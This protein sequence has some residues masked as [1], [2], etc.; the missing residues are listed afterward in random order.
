MAF[1][2]VFEG[3][4][5]D[6]TGKEWYYEIVSLDSIG[7]TEKE[8]IVSAPGVSLTYE[9]DS[10]AYS[11]AM[12]GSSL[13]M[14]LILT[15]NQLTKLE[16]LIALD[17]GRAGILFYNKQ[18]GGYT[19]TDTVETVDLGLEWVGHLLIEST[20]I[21]IVNENH[22]V[23]LLFTCGLGSLKYFDWTGDSGAYT[24][25]ARLRDVL[26]RA[27]QKTPGYSLL[28]EKLDTI[29]YGP[30]LAQ[31]NFVFEAGLP[32]A[33]SGT[34][35]A[36][37]SNYE[38]GALYTNYVHS[39]TFLKPKDNTERH[40]N[41]FEA[42]EF[43]NCYDVV[44]DVCKTLG[45]CIAMTRGGWFVWNRSSLINFSDN[46]DTIGIH[47]HDLRWV[48]SSG[49]TANMAFN[50]TS[51]DSEYL[52]NTEFNDIFLSNSDT[53]YTLSGATE[54]RTLPISGALM[55]HED[56]ESDI[57]VAEGLARR[58][59]RGLDPT[60]GF[61]SHSL[62]N[63]NQLS[64]QLSANDQ[65]SY[66]SNRNYGYEYIFDFTLYDYE[67]QNVNPSL[68]NSL[69]TDNPTFRVGFPDRTNPNL[70]VEGG[71]D[72]MFSL[73]G[74][75]TLRK[76]YTQSTITYSNEPGNVY[77]LKARIQVQHTDGTI[78]RL[79]RLVVVDND[80]SNDI[81]WEGPS[82]FSLASGNHKL[83]TYGDL[84]W[85]ADDGVGYDDA[86]YEIM[87]PHGDNVDNDAGRENV[88]TQ[89]PGLHEGQNHYAGIHLD[90]D[91]TE[92]NPLQS[93]NSALEGAYRNLYFKEGINFQ[94]PGDDSDL[95]KQVILS[96]RFSC[97]DSEGNTVFESGTDDVTFDGT[98]PLTTS[99]HE[100]PE[101]LRLAQAQI[102]LGNGS[103]DM[104]LLT[105]ATGGSGF[106]TLNIGSSRIGSRNGLLNPQVTGHLTSHV[107]TGTQWDTNTGD[108]ALDGKG[109]VN[110]RW[111]PYKNGSTG[112]PGESAFP[113]LHNLLCHEYVKVYGA[114]RKSFAGAIV[115]R[116]EGESFLRPYQIFKTEYYDDTSSHQIMM[117][118]MAWSMMNGT[119]FEGISIDED[120]Y[121]EVVSVE[122][123]KPRGPGSGRTPDKPGLG[124]VPD[125]LTIGGLSDEIDGIGGDIVAIQGKTD[126]ITGDADG[127][128]GITFANGSTPIDADAVDD[129]TAGNKF[130]TSD[131]IA[132]LGHITV[133]SDVDLNNISGV[134]DDD[135]EKLSHISADTNGITGITVEEGD[136]II[137]TGAISGFDTAVSD[138]AD[139][140]ANSEK[141]SFSG[142]NITALS[143]VD[144]RLGASDAITI[145]QEDPD[146][147]EIPVY[148]SVPDYTGARKFTVQDLYTAL[149]T[150][151]IDT[152]VTDGQGTLPDFT[153]S[154]SNILGD[155]DNDGAVG[156]A[157]LLAF[158]ANFGENFTTATQEDYWQNTSW[159]YDRLNLIPPNP[160]AY[161]N[162]PD[163]NY[164]WRVL[165]FSNITKNQVIGSAGT[166]S[167]NILDNVETVEIV[168]TN[169]QMPM[170]LFPLKTFQIEPGLGTTG[171]V[172]V[173]ANVVPNLPGIKV[174]F[175]CEIKT[176][177]D[178]D[179][180][181]EMSGANGDTYMSI[182][183]P[184]TLENAGQQYNIPVTDIKGSMVWPIISNTDVV[185]IQ[186]RWFIRP[187][188]LRSN[189][190]TGEDPV[191]IDDAE[192]H[193]NFTYRLGK[194]RQT[195]IR[196]NV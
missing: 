87:I 135:A 29:G 101:R 142:A 40:R 56:A 122:E 161:T 174:H 92:E 188:V 193:S 164:N 138:N 41:L 7:N 157:D 143:V 154:T 180:P 150:S 116:E 128:S 37:E 64:W 187:Y 78:Y 131:D 132:K 72:F 113:S 107:Y 181:V 4:I 95:F 94:F 104:D 27:L 105:R 33:A 133:S 110:V 48:V 89:I 31:Y 169:D 171:S 73:R 44:E 45:A 46:P 108:D 82:S 60:P 160:F 152:I 50:L 151:L 58:R 9:S 146:L 21:D 88:L 184:V 114:Q 15:D 57:V 80:S 13:N 166:L 63:Q 1:S 153:G 100:L 162:T 172:G 117:T 163:G 170:S 136:T 47:T 179:D 192:Y 5:S 155:L 167:L 18:P 81:G 34:G 134:S 115:S 90:Y 147:L 26:Y 36:H 168:N 182:S 65:Y 10:L 23:D 183:F 28:L 55:T 106:E 98:Y 32:Q 17:E 66:G 75:L 158:L 30:V 123:T 91:D 68:R 120:R 52:G 38:Y 186:L 103:E 6:A 22:R 39:R 177:D 112:G 148:S 121:T 85:I 173:V 96:W 43:I 25:R 83:K 53:R 70:R 99:A 59:F 12:L 109:F 11:K 145:L 67:D 97:L 2:I 49:G 71:Q 125:G 159:L 76:K 185:K 77:I 74:D 35:T 130:V 191:N 194:F 129:S 165:S 8:A 84:E 118:R 195:I 127:I 140:S 69:Q 119:S 126:N 178:N 189:N 156:A 111:L 144:N 24:D 3:A 14:S 175:G 190:N 61:G 176:F 137:G 51:S 102:R 19:T 62:F 124:N 16:S 42:P 86:W 149:T 54:G 139:V 196:R 79:S 141:V 93:S 20:T